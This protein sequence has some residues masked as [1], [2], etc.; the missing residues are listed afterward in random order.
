MKLFV[1]KSKQH[2]REH[3]SIISESLEIAMS[4]IYRLNICN[5]KLWTLEKYLET[6]YDYEVY[7]KDEVVFFEND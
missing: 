2:G 3:I 6:F 5:P 7:G 1:W 4:R